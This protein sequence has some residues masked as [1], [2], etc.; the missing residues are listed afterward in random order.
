MKRK[1][2]NKKALF[3][4]LLSGIS[5]QTFKRNDKIKHF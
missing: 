5:Y 3:Q 1:R 4:V 2:K